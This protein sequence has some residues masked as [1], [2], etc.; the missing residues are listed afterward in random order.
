[1]ETVL[2]FGYA[3]IANEAGRHS[4]D[5]SFAGIDGYAAHAARTAVRP[6]VEPHL[7]PPRHRYGATRLEQHE[8]A[9]ARANTRWKREWEPRTAHQIMAIRNIIRSVLPTYWRD[10]E[11]QR[12]RAAVDAAQRL[13]QAADN[14][15][16]RA[17]AL[18]RVTTPTRRNDTG[19]V[20]DDR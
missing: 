7:V 15:R 1:M 18:Q 19:Q 2:D 8:N 9:L 3:L 16:T 10:S 13:L 20:Q 14:E 4:V 11:A 12:T 6:Y 17:K 5:P